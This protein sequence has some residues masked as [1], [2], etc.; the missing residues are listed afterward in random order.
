MFNLNYN[1]LCKAMQSEHYG[2]EYKN[3]LNTYKYWEQV[4][5]VLKKLGEAPDVK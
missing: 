2:V 5:K 4:N 1:K 3:K